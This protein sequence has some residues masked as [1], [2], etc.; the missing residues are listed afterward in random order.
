MENILSVPEDGFDDSEF[1]E[2]AEN[3]GQ[4]GRALTR[5]ISGIVGEALIRCH[6]AID[7]SNQVLNAALSM[8]HSFVDKP[9]QVIN[10]FTQEIK[11]DTCAVDYIETA[12]SLLHRIHTDYNDIRNIVTGGGVDAW[13][14]TSMPAPLPPLACLGTVCF[15][16]LMPV[17]LTVTACSAL[18]QMIIPALACSAAA[19]QTGIEVVQQTDA[20]VA[21][22]PSSA[23]VLERTPLR[24]PG[25]FQPAT[26][27]QKEDA[28]PEE[29]TRTTLMLRNIPIGITR[30]TIMDVLRSEGLVDH[31]TF[32]YVPM[33]L[34]GSGNFGYAF[35]DF[36]STAA[37]EL[38]KDRL[39]GFSGW[40]EPGETAL[41]TVWS[42]SQG[43]DS[44]IQRYR[45]SPIMHRSLEDE[46][47]PAMFKNGARIAFPPPTKSIRAPRLRKGAN[48]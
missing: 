22:S 39:D 41:E 1:A 17:A 30:S 26:N 19:P 33:N 20:P 2:Y 16:P 23:P 10:I 34:R 11:E 37:A 12:C 5:R 36:D 27:S 3:H 25:V 35:V 48:Q 13:Y 8:C 15:A 45:D 32:I 31:L 21:C 38:C 7:K 46:L 40:S 29:T 6:S 42:E 24:P 18:N 47:K 28:L 43:I 4:M 14:L 44:H 9:S